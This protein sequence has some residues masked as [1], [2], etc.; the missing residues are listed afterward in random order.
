MTFS[1]GTYR[2]RSL[3]RLRSTWKTSMLHVSQSPK[4]SRVHPTNPFCGLGPW[5]GHWSY[6]AWCGVRLY[7]DIVLP[8]YLKQ[9]YRT[10]ALLI[11]YGDKSKNPSFST[12]RAVLNILQDH[13]PERL[14]AALIINVPFLLNAFYK[15]INPF[16]DPVSR[17]KMKFNPQ[18]V[19]DNIFT[20]DM[21]MAEWGGDRSFE[22]VH[23][24]YWPSLVE[25]CEARRKAW[26][27]GWRAAGGKIGA[28]E[29]DYKSGAG[30]SE[31]GGGSC[32]CIGIHWFGEDHPKFCA[33]GY[34]NSCH[35]LRRF[36]S[37]MS[38]GVY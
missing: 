21:V 38:F 25:M 31:K 33:G 34:C 30:S 35:E 12:A 4:H 13:Y 18:L 6:G 24:K 26:M 15:L 16:I 22:Y 8:F 36:C 1:L 11:N 7:P 17:E 5:T 23:E 20:A 10:L 29:W 32:S 14:G 37:T 2:K 27:D 28:K 19:K 3:V 9:Y